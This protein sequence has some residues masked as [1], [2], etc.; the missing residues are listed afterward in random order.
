MS[1]EKRFRTIK[2]SSIQVLLDFG[3]KIPL[4][5]LGE[6]LRENGVGKFNTPKALHEIKI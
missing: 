2:K 1:A 5:N 3:N 4:I 6:L